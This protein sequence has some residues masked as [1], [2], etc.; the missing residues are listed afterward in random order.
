[1]V[2]LGR[3]KLDIMFEASCP[4]RSEALG[5][6]NLLSW[7]SLA[8]CSLAGSG[9]PAE[10]DAGCAAPP[11]PTL[12]AALRMSMRTAGAGNPVPFPTSPETHFRGLLL[13]CWQPAAPSFLYASRSFPNN[14]Q[15]PQVYL[16]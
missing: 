4:L 15:R 7:G 12:A 16:P 9:Q 14:V 5:L 2:A 1:L 13:R 6:A 3:V 8:R 10:N 11:N